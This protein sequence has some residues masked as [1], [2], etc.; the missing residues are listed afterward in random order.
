MT[1]LLRTSWVSD[2]EAGAAAAACRGVG[3]L[4]L[5]RRAAERFDEIHGAAR[6]KVEAYR[7]DHQLHPIGFADNIVGIRLVGEVELVLE[8]RASAAFHRQAQ[9]RRTPLF[10][11][12]GAHAAGGGF[13]EHETLRHISDVGRGVFSLK[14]SK[15]TR[16]SPELRA[17]PFPAGT[18]PGLG[19]RRRRQACPDRSP[20]SG[21]CAAV[22][23]VRPHRA[24]WYRVPP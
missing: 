23:S 4:H 17:R 11:G 8:T 15:C 20:A 2:A 18:S 24:R 3:I 5:E 9:D 21:G 16:A 10:A 13:G 6:D 14:L 7:V 22:S 12:N 19:L 1:R